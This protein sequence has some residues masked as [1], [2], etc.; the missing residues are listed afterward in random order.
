MISPIQIALQLTAW[1]VALAWFWKVTDATF[2]LPRIPNLLLP[3]YNITPA[4]S[5]S[6]TVIV[7]ARNEAADIA[8]TLNSLL[9]QDYANLHIIAVDDRSTDQTGAI[10]DTIA[11]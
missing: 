11:S 2:G 5:P 8:A 7:P 3:E 1:L 6:I 9:E 4:G 10:I